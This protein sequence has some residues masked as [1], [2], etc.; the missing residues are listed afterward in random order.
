MSDN[1]QPTAE[2]ARIITSAKNLG[3]EMDETDALQWLSAMAASQTGGDITLDTRAGVFGH[4]VTMLDFS[5]TDLARF[6]EIGR[7]VEF[8][9]QPGIVETALALSGS[10]AQSK[11]QTYPGDCDY[12]ERINI[13]APTRA[14]AC[15][16]LGTIMH[17]KILGTAKGATHQFIEAKL[18]SYPRDVVREGKTK[19]AG[20]PI[21]WELEDVRAGKI[22]AFT[23]DGAPITITWD[24]MA[25]NPG[26]CKLDWVIADPT[27]GQLANA[28]NMLDVTWQAPD[29]TITPL[30]GYLDPY[31]QEVYLDATSIPIFSKLAQNVSANAL[32][33]YVAQL[34]N[35]V[36]KYVTKDVNYGKAAKRMYNIFRLT[37]R[38]DEAAYIREL[39]DEPATLLYQVWSL[40]RTIEDV[41]QPDSSISKTQLLAQADQLIISVITALEG[42]QEAEIVKHLLKLKN[43]LAQNAEHGISADVEAARARVINIVNNFFHERLVALPTIRTYIENFQH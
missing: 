20:T 39:F 24:E 27:R 32:D 42:E 43:A 7:L 17:D 12:F 9:D 37:G 21:A 3:V 18:G 19:K 33:D 30:D 2:L 14:D 5:S 35:E 6:R 34:E 11:I 29:G 40:I 23:P 1:A 26:W 22:D 36:K 13:L 41:A 15:K 25:Q 16:I 28:S 4:K 8:A 31:F 10:A 38:Y